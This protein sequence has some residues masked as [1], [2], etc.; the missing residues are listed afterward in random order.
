MQSMQANQT[1]VAQ[2][3]STWRGVR[4]RTQV[5]LGL[6]CQDQ[7]KEK[8]KGNNAFPSCVIRGFQGDQC[9]DFRNELN[10]CKANGG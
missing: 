2:K 9:A 7:L 5:R 6:S 1:T 10:A 3:L 8:Y 4:V